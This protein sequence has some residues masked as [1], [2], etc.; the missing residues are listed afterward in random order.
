MLPR[1]L[2]KTTNHGPDPLAS[3]CLN[4]T[5]RTRMKREPACFAKLLYPTSLTRLPSEVSC[6]RSCPPVTR[7]S[8]GCTLRMRRASRDPKS[9]SR[10][11]GRWSLVV[12]EVWR[13]K[14]S[15]GGG[16][17]VQPGES[18]GGASSTG[19]VPNTGKRPCSGGTKVCAGREEVGSAGLWDSELGAREP[20]STIE[21]VWGGQP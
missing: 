5:H 15:D 11:P 3:N 9:L 8:Q 1:P 17:G 4:C 6:G 18:P 21:E 19:G 20:G 16:D 14:A 10:T 12:E 13:C 7:L 2:R